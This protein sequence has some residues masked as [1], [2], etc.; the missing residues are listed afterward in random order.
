MAH[1]RAQQHGPCQG[2]GVHAQLQ[3][4]QQP[5]KPKMRS[6]KPIMRSNMAAALKNEHGHSHADSEARAMAQP[7]P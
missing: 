3:G 1:Q 4:Q 7:I 5:G 2:E 6:K